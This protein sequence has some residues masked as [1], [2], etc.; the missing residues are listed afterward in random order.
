LTSGA[1]PCYRVLARHR[2][3]APLRMSP[4]IWLS[5]ADR[6]DYKKKNNS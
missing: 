4:I 6:E 1:D 3:N 2:I 5:L